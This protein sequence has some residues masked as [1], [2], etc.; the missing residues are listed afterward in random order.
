VLYYATKITQWLH[1][2]HGDRQGVGKWVSGEDLSGEDL[3][4]GGCQRN[5]AYDKCRCNG[6]PTGLLD[7]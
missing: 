6:V 4:E 1:G 7:V 2:V 3:G 5:I